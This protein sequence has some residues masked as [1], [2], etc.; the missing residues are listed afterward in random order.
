MINAT[1]CDTAM[2]AIL[3][4]LIELQFGSTRHGQDARA[5]GARHTRFTT[6]I[7]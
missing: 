7:V 5:A 6:T 4:M 1:N 2:L 3:A